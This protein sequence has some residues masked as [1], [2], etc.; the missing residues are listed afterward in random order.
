MYGNV[1]RISYKSHQPNALKPANNILGK[2]ED[3]CRSDSQ[4]IEVIE[5]MSTEKLL[6]RPQE[7]TSTPL[8][9]QSVTRESRLRRKYLPEMNFSDR[10]NI[11]S[12]TNLTP[13]DLA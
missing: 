9:T 12:S 10:E 11:Y 7:R 5:V 2:P 3:P 4:N 13:K 6:V 1:I 8:A